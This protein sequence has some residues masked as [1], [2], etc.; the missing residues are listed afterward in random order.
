MLK[1]YHLDGRSFSFMEERTR[2]SHDQNTFTLIVGK[3]GTGKSR[4]LRSIVMQF[5]RPSIAPDS[6]ARD[7]RIA[8]ENEGAGDV[9]MEAAPSKIICVSTS[10]FDRFPLLRREVHEEQYSYLGLRGLPSTNLGLAYLSRVLSSLIDASYKSRP[11]ANAITKVLG[12]LGYQGVIQASFHLPPSLF[13]EELTSA[14][15]PRLFLQE[16]LGSGRGFPLQDSIISLRQLLSLSDSDLHQILFIARKV[17]DHKV[18]GKITI[19]INKRGVH[20]GPETHMSSDDMVMLASSG[21]LRLRDIHLYKNQ[22]GPLK[23]NDASS[24]EQAVVMSL[25][26]IGSQIRDGSLICIDEP[27]V[28]LH[29]EWQER[30]IEL[31]FSTFR[32]YRGCHFLIATHSP[33]IVAQLPHGNCYVMSMEDGRAQPAELFAHRSIDFQ[34]AEVFNSPGYKNEYLNRI[35]LNVFARVSKA[36]ALDDQSAADLA[37]LRKANPELQEGDPLRELI[38]AL[39]EMATLYA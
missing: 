4:L 14:S 39:E 37:T 17:V 25:L 22:F 27:E 24:G 18:R 33:Q 6:F 19:E 12:Y 16:Y 15:E 2:E 23:V 34:L 7:D 11:R 1:S 9:E 35:A 13:L 28:C 5:I 21:L 31:L 30:Y 29:P 36:K 10:P 20:A 3:N 26:G 8:W 38:G 32:S